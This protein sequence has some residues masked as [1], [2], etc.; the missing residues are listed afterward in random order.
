[1]ISPDGVRRDMERVGEQ[2][3]RWWTVGC[4]RRSVQPT[5]THSLGLGSLKKGMDELEFQHIHK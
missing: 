3:R 1:M 5:H 2:G 4:V